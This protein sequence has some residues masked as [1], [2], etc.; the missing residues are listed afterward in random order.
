MTKLG[1]CI[2]I[3]VVLVVGGFLSML[4]FGDGKGGPRIGERWRRSMPSRL[5]SPSL[6]V[7]VAGVAPDAIA[8]SYPHRHSTR[9]PVED[10]HRYRP[11]RRL[12]QDST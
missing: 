10:E 8:D 6:T 7:P 12:A 4:S 11:I 1:W 9:T 2:L 5:A 3:A